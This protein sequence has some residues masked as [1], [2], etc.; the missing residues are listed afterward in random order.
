MILFLA[1]SETNFLKYSARKC[2]PYPSTYG[3]WHNF[4]IMNFQDIINRCIQNWY[5]VVVG[6]YVLIV[7][8]LCD[9]YLNFV[10]FLS[11]NVG[12]QNGPKLSRCID[13]YFIFILKIEQ[14]II[15]RSFSSCLK[16][17]PQKK[18]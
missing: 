10:L 2:W 15:V 3:R 14:D 1:I 7:Y 17:Q 9:Q 8:I 11:P 16:C 6:S 5:L 4:I 18:K 12:I 13:I